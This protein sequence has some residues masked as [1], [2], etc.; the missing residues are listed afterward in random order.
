MLRLK[1]RS[2]TPGTLGK[3]FMVAVLREPSFM[4]K[5]W[6]LHGNVADSTPSR[7]S[8][9]AANRK[10]NDTIAIKLHASL[11]FHPLLWDHFAA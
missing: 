3:K 11:Q 1:A 10:A 2:G 4:I 5:L 8:W 7:S 9:R 6:Y